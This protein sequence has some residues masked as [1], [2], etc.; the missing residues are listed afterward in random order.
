MRERKLRGGVVAGEKGRG[1]AEGGLVC[2]RG[3]GVGTVENSQK[4]V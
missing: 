3:D 1:D 4:S 2:V